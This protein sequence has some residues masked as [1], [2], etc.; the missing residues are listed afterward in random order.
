VALAELLDAVE[1]CDVYDAPDGADLWARAR[2]ELD[3]I[4]GVAA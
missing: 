3:R 1:V 2:A 4:M